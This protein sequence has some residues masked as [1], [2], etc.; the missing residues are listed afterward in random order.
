MKWVAS[1][2]RLGGTI[3]CSSVASRLMIFWR[4]YVIACQ[5]F[6]DRTNISLILLLHGS[7]CL[8]FEWHFNLKFTTTWIC[9][10]VN[11]GSMLP[12]HI[13]FM[14]KFWIGFFSLPL[15]LSV[16]FV[17]SFISTWH[18][19]YQNDRISL[20]FNPILT[21]DIL[22]CS[23]SSALQSSN[24]K[25]ER[26]WITNCGPLIANENSNANGNNAQVW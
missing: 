26:I 6:W 7:F 14:C 13:K 16:H 2:G 12:L 8:S 18:C 23:A 21:L 17:H 25:I 15:F 24:Q 22:F 19:V 1:V 10:C 3:T 4:S 5:Q 9:V 11:F 20:K